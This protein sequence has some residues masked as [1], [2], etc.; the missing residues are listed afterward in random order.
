MYSNNKGRADY[1]ICMFKKL[2]EEEE[3]EDKEERKTDALGKF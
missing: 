1:Y 2:E 3:E